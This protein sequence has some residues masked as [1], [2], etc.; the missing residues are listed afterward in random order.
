MRSDELDALIL[1]LESMPGCVARAT[2]VL[3]DAGARRAPAP[4]SFSLV[5]H[6]WHLADLERD[7]YAVRLARLR[8]EDGPHL[9]DFDGD[10][11]AAERAY[12]TLSLEEGLAA[13]KHARAENVR[14]LRA[15]AGAEWVRGGTQEGVGAVR[16]CDIPRMMVHHDAGHRA[17]LQALLAG[18]PAWARES[19]CA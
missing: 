16:L 19:A 2:E 3:D 15:I 1:A 10:R 4:G 5:E 6:V 7:G 18:E 11:I 14:T 13:F 8:A 12:R 9:S 17:E